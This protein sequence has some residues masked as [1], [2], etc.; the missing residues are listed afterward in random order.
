I[1]FFNGLDQEISKLY[2]TCFDD[3]R[4]LI[5]ELFLIAEDNQKLILSLN[6]NQERVVGT[7]ATTSVEIAGISQQIAD[8]QSRAKDVEPLPRRSLHM[9]TNQLLAAR[10]HTPFNEAVERIYGSNFNIEA[11]KLLTVDQP[12]F[13][14]Q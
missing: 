11:A 10:R 4:I 1:T 12:I 5:E 7:I 8:W 6:G 3:N 9:R 14:L 13:S 2:K